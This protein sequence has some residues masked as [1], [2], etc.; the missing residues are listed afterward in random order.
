MTAEKRSSR[1]TWLGT[2]SDSGLWWALLGVVAVLVALSLAAW[3]FLGRDPGIDAPL[4]APRDAGADD[5]AGT[6]G[7]VLVFPNREA[8]G[9]V[10]ETRQLPSR[11]RLEEDLLTILTTLCAGPERGDAVSAVPAGTRPLGVFYDPESREVVLDFSRELV[12]GHPGGSTGESAT[13]GSILKT[14]GV[15]F[16]EIA[17][18]R[19]LVEGAPVETLAGHFGL[20]EPFE[21]R[22]WR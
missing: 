5:L 13:L 2:R 15:N 8:T 11:A 1:R 17:V 7:V 19:L 6:R 18:C 14:V 10:T 12:T 22:R 3:L 16:P 21:L 9:L 4:T 20:D